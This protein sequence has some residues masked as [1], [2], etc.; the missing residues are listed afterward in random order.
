MSDYTSKELILG[1]Q[2][3]WQR[4]ASMAAKFHHGQFRKDGKTPYIA[5][6]Y[7]VAMT[8]RDVFNVD[9][10]VALAAALLHDVLEDTT[11]DYDD[12]EG[13]FG[14]E[15]A[16]VVA[17]LTKDM[18]RPEA[19]REA[20]YDRG[21]AAAPWEA[22]LIK[23]ADVYDN[24]SDCMTEGMRKKAIEKAARAVAIAGN[25]PQV[26][27]AARKVEALIGRAMQSDR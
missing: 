21:L 15:V 23:L 1:G 11:A 27:A 8:V 2:P 24:V 22:R 26:K 9:D 16:D 4:A 20:E 6:P 13:A 12:L 3:I 17:A 25:E 18:R 10:P 7:R 14:A 5:H 19:V